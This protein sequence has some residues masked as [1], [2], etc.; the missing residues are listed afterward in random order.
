MSKKIIGVT[1][2]T[3]TSASR[4]GRELKPE[5]EEYVDGKISDIEAIAKGAVAG[6]SF[7]DYATLIE[8]LN[9]AGETD[10]APAQHMLIKTLGVPDVW[11][12]EVSQEHVP[13]EYIDD[14]TFAVA[15]VEGVVQVGYYVLSA[16]E[17]QK[18]DLTDYVEKYNEGGAT[19]FYGVNRSGTQTMIL[20]GDTDGAFSIGRVAMYCSD[21]GSSN[22]NEPA[23][24]LNTKM[25]TKDYQCANKKYV[26][27]SLSDYAMKK[28]ETDAGGYNIVPIIA[29]DGKPTTLRIYNAPL[30]HAIP[31]YATGGFLSTNA[32]EK[33]KHCANKK[34][35]DDLVG[36]ISAA[37]D[38]LLSYAQSLV[39]GG[40]S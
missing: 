18:V 9:S 17:T 27:D 20:G 13:Y 28:P 23:G 29:G 37:L 34:Y 31:Q 35:V 32:P 2:G 19:R 4:I 24:A 11:V 3:T 12:Y 25:P 38:E 14:E 6:I 5:I 26:D 22:K 36:D 8:T 16:L 10:Y 21:A 7:M 15:V 33:D 40:A 30:Q 1:V 39:D